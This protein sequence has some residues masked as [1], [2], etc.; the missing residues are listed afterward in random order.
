MHGE[1]GGSV[2]GAAVAEGGEI[3]VREQVLARSQEDGAE[4]EVQLVD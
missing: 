2:L 4:G 1:L 3:D